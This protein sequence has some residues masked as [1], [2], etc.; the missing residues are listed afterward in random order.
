MSG[1]SRSVRPSGTLRVFAL[2]LSVW[3]WAVPQVMYSKTIVDLFMEQGNGPISIIEEEEVRH[4]TTAPRSTGMVTHSGSQLPALVPS[5]FKL[6][7]FNIL[8]GEVPEPPPW[9]NCAA[10]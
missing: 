2:I 7:P 8:H 1:P 6:L 10:A 3:L 5:E 4:A 9:R